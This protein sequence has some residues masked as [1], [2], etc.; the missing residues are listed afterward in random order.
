[1]SD[2]LLT[3]AEVAEFGAGPG[4][5]GRDGYAGEHH[6]GEDTGAAARLALR[7]AIGVVWVVVVRRHL[8]RIASHDLGDRDVAWGHGSGL[9]S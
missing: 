5:A 4:R 7:S 8:G 1:M 9:G 6:A 3:A 2:R